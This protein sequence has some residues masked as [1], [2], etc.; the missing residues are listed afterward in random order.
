[1]Q[2][3]VVGGKPLHLHPRCRREVLGP[4]GVWN[5][6]Q[7]VLHDVVAPLVEHEAP[8]PCPAQQVHTGVSQLR[9]IH[10]QK[11]RR[12]L[13]VN[14]HCRYMSMQSY[15]SVGRALLA[16]GCL[17]FEVVS[18]THELNAVVRQFLFQPTP[19]V[20][21][22]LVVLFIVDGANYIGGGEPPLAVL[23]VPNGSHLVVVEKTYGFLIAHCR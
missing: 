10:R 5:H 18:D 12:V 9:R 23:L 20:T 16:V 11:I 4:V 7:V 21:G 17:K 15:E 19:I 3:F 6:H 2:E 13:K 1:M 22:F 8:F 14:L